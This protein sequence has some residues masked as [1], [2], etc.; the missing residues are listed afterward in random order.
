MNIAKNRTVDIITATLNG[1]PVR[2][3]SHDHECDYTIS[4]HDLSLFCGFE[5][6]V[7]IIVLLLLSAQLHYYDYYCEYYYDFW[8]V[9]SP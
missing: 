4:W 6:D 8:N 7:Y 2:T 3:H 5:F 9:T 1:D